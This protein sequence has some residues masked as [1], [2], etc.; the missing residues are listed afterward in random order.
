MESTKHQLAA[1]GV[2]REKIAAPKTAAAADKQIEDDG[3][4]AESADELKGES[5]EDK[6][7]G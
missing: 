5:D 6:M 1:L 2:L 4:I 7:E 3:L